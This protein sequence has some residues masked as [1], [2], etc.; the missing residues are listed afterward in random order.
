M[1]LRKANIRQPTR[2][3]KATPTARRRPSADSLPVFDVAGHDA[4]QRMSARPSHSRERRRARRIAPTKLRQ[5]MTTLPVDLRARDLPALVRSGAGDPAGVER[6]AAPDRLHTDDPQVRR[7]TGHGRSRAPKA[8]EL[9]VTR[10][11]FR[12]AAQDGLGQ[13]R[14]APERDEPARVQ[15]LRMEAPEPHG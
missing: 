15:V 5:Q 4:E 9:R 11:A 8:I 13:E 3:D 2:A 6:V 14:L 7:D 10:V 1:N 12:A